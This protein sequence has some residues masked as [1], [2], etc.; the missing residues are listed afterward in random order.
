MERPWVGKGGE[1][2]RDDGDGQASERVSELGF[3][4]LL[5]GRFGVNSEREWTKWALPGLWCSGTKLNF[6]RRTALPC[7]ALAALALP[8]LGVSAP[9]P[10]PSPACTLR[11]FALFG[12]LFA[13]LTLSLASGFPAL[14]CPTLYSTPSLSLSSPGRFSSVSVVAGMKGCPGNLCTAPPAC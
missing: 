2:G 1:G 4:V 10:G 5:P 14:P 3:G 7:T 9:I 12:L 8:L 6:W 13:A 11:T